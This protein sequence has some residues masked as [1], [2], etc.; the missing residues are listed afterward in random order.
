MIMDMKNT[1]HFP[2]SI[3]LWERGGLS[4]K[5]TKEVGTVLRFLLKNNW[6]QKNPKR[7]PFTRAPVQE[8]GF[9]GNTGPP[10]AQPLK[11]KPSPTP[12]KTWHCPCSDRD[13][14]PCLHLSP[15]VPSTHKPGIPGLWWWAHCS[16]HCGILSFLSQW[17]WLFL[18]LAGL[19]R[20][21]QIV[22]LLP[23]I[24]LFCPS[25]S[26]DEGVPMFWFIWV[27]HP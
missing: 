26:H 21:W 2:E 3:S 18:V 1:Y 7:A 6:C 17:G 10:I 8:Q 22:P 11:Q 23:R 14:N 4:S 16:L 12:T 20:G 19:S 5:R 13:R 25:L 15:T 27:G 24:V 9:F